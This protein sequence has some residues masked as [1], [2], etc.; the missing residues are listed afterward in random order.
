MIVVRVRVRTRRIHVRSKGEAKPVPR[1]QLREDAFGVS[2]A[3]FAAGEYVRHVRTSKVGDV[4]ERND[5]DVSTVADAW[6]QDVG[7]LAGVVL[8]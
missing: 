1:K 8:G 3:R 4:V 7:W 6:A 5:D 2:N